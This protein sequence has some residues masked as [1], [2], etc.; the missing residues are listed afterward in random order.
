MEVSTLIT[1]DLGQIEY[2]DE[3]KNE[4]ITEIG[5]VVRFEYSLKAIYEWEHK[6]RK[7]FL[8]GNLSREEY[9]DFY[10]LMALDPVD[11]KFID[12]SVAMKLSKYISDSGTATVFNTMGDSSG[13]RKSSKIYTSEELYA[14]MALEN[15]PIEFENRNLNRLL[16]ILRVIASYKE[17]PKKMSKEAIVKQNSE[18]NRL[19]REQMKTKG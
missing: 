19:R 7:P 17:P 16:T 9:M 15:I 18:L 12:D 6:W 4:F 1:I 5:G 11:V 3:S 8:K 13:G 10:M 2:Y 14:L